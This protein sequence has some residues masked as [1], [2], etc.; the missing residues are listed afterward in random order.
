MGVAWLLIHVADD[1]YYY[2][3]YGKAP[4]PTSYFQLE[5]EQPEVGRVI[6]LDSFSKII[7]AGIRIGFASGPAPILDVI[8]IHVRRPKHALSVELLLTICADL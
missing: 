4:R 5:L 3:Y 1:P 6:R 2:I 7:S 8:D